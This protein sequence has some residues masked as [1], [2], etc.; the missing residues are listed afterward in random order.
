MGNGTQHLPVPTPG[1]VPGAGR[2]AESRE[3]YSDFAGV[4]EWQ[5]RWTQNPVAAR[6]CG[7]NSHL[8]YFSS[9]SSLAKGGTEKG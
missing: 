6:P 4:A 3:W 9:F 2:E 5:T 8:R 1:Q 7:F